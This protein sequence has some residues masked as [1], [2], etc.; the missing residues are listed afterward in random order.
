MLAEDDERRISVRKRSGVE[1]SAEARAALHVVIV[2]LGDGDN[3]RGSHV[4]VC[5]TDKQMTHA[6]PTLTLP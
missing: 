1:L 5:D 4:T 6:S 2:S 3:R